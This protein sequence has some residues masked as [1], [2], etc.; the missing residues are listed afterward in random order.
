MGRNRESRMLAAGNTIEVNGNT[1]TVRP[2]VAQH[3][4]DLEQEALRYYKRQYI[5]TFKDNTDVLG[6]GADEVLREKL[7]EI[8]HWDLSK[9]PQRDAYDSSK[10][11]IT[12]ELQKWG[13][14]ESEEVLTDTALKGL[15]NVSLDNGVITSEE[16]REMTGKAPQHGKI[17]YDQWW[18]TGSAAG[19]ISMITSSLNQ[20]HPEVTRKDVASWPFVKLAEVSRIVG[21][22]T[23]PDLKN[24]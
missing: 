21:G 1:Y 16:V 10:C 19:M 6:D 17:R 18:V 4:C 5:Q 14:A 9:L 24:G 15:L 13:V 12:K 3:L 22:L 7:E 23:Q 11:P 8:A 2:V 20:D